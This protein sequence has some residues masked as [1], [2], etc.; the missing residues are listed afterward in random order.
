M[1]LLTNL[2]AYDWTTWLIGIWRSVAQGGSNGVL[3]GLVSMGID[4]VHFNLTSGLSHLLEMIGGMFILSALIGMFTFLST[5]GA[6]D[7]AGVQHAL[8]EAAVANIQAG[9][10]IDKAQQA[11]QNPPK[12]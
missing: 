9:T 5:H 2:G 12:P 6:P 8:D 4:P 7:P 3:S 10:A 11:S 1:K